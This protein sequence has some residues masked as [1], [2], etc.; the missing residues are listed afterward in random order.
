MVWPP[1]SIDLEYGAAPRVDPHEGDH[2]AWDWDE[3]LEM[4]EEYEKII[5]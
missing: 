2:S 5:N 1:K 3:V 4:V